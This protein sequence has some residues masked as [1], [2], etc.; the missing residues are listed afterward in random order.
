MS[1]QYDIYDLD[2]PLLETLYNQ[3]AILIMDHILL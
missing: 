3:M 2:Q 1:G